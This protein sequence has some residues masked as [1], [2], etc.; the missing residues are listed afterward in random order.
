MGPVEL[1]LQ[2]QEFAGWAKYFIHCPDT[3]SKV[4]PISAHISAKRKLFAAQSFCSRVYYSL[5]Q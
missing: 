3:C 5:P 2:G 4:F 1:Q